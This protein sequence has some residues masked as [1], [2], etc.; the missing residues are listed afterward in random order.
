MRSLAR[1]PVRTPTGRD[2]AAF[3]RGLLA[4]VLLLAGG[5]A[6]E[7]DDHHAIPAEVEAQAQYAVFP[8]AIGAAEYGPANWVASPNYTNASRKT[9]QVTKVVVHTIQGSYAGCISWFKNTSSKVSAHYVVSKKG[10]ITQMVKEEDIGWHVGSANGYTIGIEH[11]GFV[12]DPQWATPAMVSASA[13][14]TCYLLKK[15]GLPADRTHVVGHVELP[16]Q[17]HTDPGK[18]WPWDKYMSEIKS[19][20]GGGTTPTCPG[21]CDDGNPCTT[22]E[23]SNGKCVNNYANG[24]VCWDGDACTAGEKCSNGK[25]VGGSIVKDCNDNNPCTNDG[26]SA[27]NC[28]HSNNSAACDDGNPCTTGDACKS[29]K[30]AAGSAKNCN[31]NNA[32][33]VDA[34]DAKT[35]NCTHASKGACD[36]GDPCTV[37]DSCDPKSGS[38]VGGAPKACDDGNACTTGDGCDPLSGACKA[39]KPLDC[40]GDG[41]PCTDGQCNPAT[42]KCAAANEGKACDDGNACTS[43]DTCLAGVC[44]GK[45]GGLNCD[46]G[47]PCTHDGCGPGGCTHTPHNLFC[48]DGNPCTAGD[49]CATGAC[50][51]VAVSCDD[52]NPCTVGEACKPGGGCTAGISACDD[53]NDCTL[54]TCKS[55]AC[56]Y[57]KVASLVCEDGDLCSEGDLCEDGVCKA[58]AAKDCAD[59]D[60]C[61]VDRCKPAEGC[62]YDTKAGCGSGGDGGATDDRDGVGGQDGLAG[63]DGGGVTNPNALSP[64]APASGCTASPRPGA[65]LGTGWL[66]LLALLPLAWRRRPA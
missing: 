39:G 45:A 8:M 36:D 55:G 56:S 44:G 18:Y 30:C 34:C 29:G 63:S 7:H 22:D 12:T 61:T 57:Q 20:M 1:T 58:G 37:A 46:D 66:L 19:C 43:G 26:C 54:D 13:K 42:G 10:E 32:C 48:D 49:S 35:G 27:G 24:I 21:S 14:L 3:A 53:G 11:E 15:W 9:G 51:G 65:P 60:P 33:T 31:D 17:T 4:L 2:G 5:C 59:G 52:G 25:C 47:N 23:C 50:V 28:T 62:V 6:A 40:V 16:K 38:C 41:D 64:S